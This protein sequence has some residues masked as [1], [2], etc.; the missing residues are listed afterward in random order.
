M[1]FASMFH[2]LGKQ[3]LGT[4]RKRFVFKDEN[5]ADVQYVTEKLPDPNLLWSP[6]VG[7]N[8]APWQ[9][10]LQVRGGSGLFSGRPAYVWISNQIGNNGILTGFEQYDN[11][12]I[13]P[14]NPNPDHYKP[15]VVT[16]DPAA[17]YELSLTDTKFNF[18][19][20]WRTNIAVDYKLP[21]GLIA[22][23]EFLYSRDM[24]GVYYINA[25][26]AAPSTAFTGADTRPR[27]TAGNRIHSNISNAIVL[28]NQDVGKS[29]NLAF[30]LEKPFSKGFYAKGAYSYG[31]AKNTVDPGSVAFGSWNNNQHSG[32]PNNPG[33]GYSAASPGHRAFVAVTYRKEYFKFGA[34]AFSALW[35]SR[36]GGNGSYVFG[37]DLN[38]DGGTSNDLIYIPRDASEMNFGNIT[39]SN[40]T[41][42]Y[43]PAEQATAWN[44]FIEQ[45]PYLS[46]HRGEYAQRGAVFLPFVHRMDF[47]VSQDVFVKLGGQ[48]HKFQVRADILNFGNLLNH[49]WGG[50][51]T[52]STTQPL[53][54]TSSS[55]ATCRV[56][57]PSTAATYCLR[58]VGSGLLNTSFTR[59][60][61]ESDVYRIQFSVKYTFN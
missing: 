51:S 1:A 59:N 25:N 11:T 30:S 29:W 7:F 5:G 2:F 16:G 37:G 27:W 6:R 55:R 39:A 32:N 41:I 10:K 50:S 15:S 48:Q 45:D 20:L 9:G 43:T 61:S 60:V 21:L 52:F 17:S 34:T 28:K 12:V 19:Q 42:L 22:G 57:T 14:W 54:T 33:L 31:E 24:N 46:K 47:S 38:G 53:V 44:S 4:R 56:A 13:R 8:W 23:S 58:T 36:T 3:G 40:G 18:P 26:L 35:E 49:N